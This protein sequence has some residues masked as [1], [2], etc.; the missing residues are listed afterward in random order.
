MSSTLWNRFVEKAAALKALLC[1]RPPE[2]R[3]QEKIVA[4]FSKL[5]YHA[6]L[7]GWTWENTY[8]LG[9]QVKKCP[10]DLWVFQ[11]LMAELR[12]D[13][14]VESGTARGGSALFMASMCDLLG[15]G[16]VITIDI[17]EHEGRPTHPRV[18]YLLGSST[19]PQI[20]AQVRELVRDAASVLVLLD[21]DHRKKHV[22]RE[23][24]LYSEFVTVGSYIIVEDT[25]VHGHPVLPEY[26]PGP[27]EAV[28]E[29]LSRNRN[30]TADRSKE[31]FYLT[32]NPKGYLRRER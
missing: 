11:E 1:R 21:S 28:E 5:F 7:L 22:L 32:H 13:V 17:E 31:K 19:S 4:D 2:S 18:K 15:H 20:V 29:F 24:E 9:V 23:L 27:M 8:W 6:G 25:N 3:S 26:P 16:R 10:F 30:F 14:V 12:P